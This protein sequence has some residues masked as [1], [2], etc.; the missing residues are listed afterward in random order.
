MPQKK[1]NKRARV[2]W[3]DRGG[4][5]RAYG[6]FRDLG[7]GREA[8]VPRGERRATTDPDIADKLAADR[9]AELERRRRSRTILGLE[10]Q[11]ALGPYA[12]HHLEEKARAGR[13]TDKTIATAECHLQRAVDFYGSD[14]YLDT[15]AVADVQN[16]RNRLSAT[17]SR[18]GG[19]LSGSSQRHY[20]NDLSNLFRRAQAEG[21]VPPGYNPVSAMMEKPSA[22][23]AEAHW[24]EVPDAAL[25][26]EAAR[27]WKPARPEITNGNMHAILAT[28]L[29]TGGRFAEVVGLTVTDV[30]FQRNTVTFRPNE[31][32]RLKTKTSHR[33]VPLWPQLREILRHYLFSRDEP[34]EG[35]LFSSPRGGGMVR[36]FRKALDPI[37]KRAGWA[38]GEIRSKVFR[39]SYCAARLQTLDRGVP[40]S[41]WTVAKELG[42]GGSR[43]VERVYGHR[44][45]IR[46]RAEVVE[47][48]AE[49][50]K[51]ARG[52]RLKALA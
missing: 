32:R 30:S 49:Q 27:T 3:R 43:L 4:E 31:F 45:T 24:L 39:H 2:Y 35:L 46:H 22:A 21:V 14:R 42:H 18:T 34:S 40:V 44:G 10:D 28:F 50:H 29:L 12:Q 5:Q 51:D 36:D 9:V 13:V 25:L 8:L 16:F 48:R 11:A 17:P 23:T 1:R 52:D 41:P 7:G 38:E 47:F 19:T 20:L 33:V 37:A 15:I 6:D 26:L